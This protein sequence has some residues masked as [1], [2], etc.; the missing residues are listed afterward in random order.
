MAS[1]DTFRSGSVRGR[2]FGFTFAALALVSSMASA[3]PEDPL[4]PFL[5]TWSGVFTTQDH[6]FWGLEDFVC[7]PGC[8]SAAYEHTISLLDDPANDAVP[9]GAIL[10]MGMGYEAEYMRGILTPLGRQI[11]DAN[12]PEN[13]PKLHCQPYG[14]IRQVMNPLPIV[15][16]RLGDHLLFR[17]E[18]WSMLRTVFLDGRPHPEFMT[19]S[20]LGHAVGRVEDGVLII[21]T[22]GLV[23]DRFSDASQAGYSGELTAVERYTVLDNPRRLELELTVEDPVTLTEPVVMTKTWLYTPDLELLADSCGDLPGIY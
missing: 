13:D 5:G 7:F 22:A 3:Q 14:F 12:L 21:E 9:A 2:R 1:G 11:Q 4:A 10:G 16:R 17:Y 23:P 20:L 18:E 6:E 19:P 15:I 8:T